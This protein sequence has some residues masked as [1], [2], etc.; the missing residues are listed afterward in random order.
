MIDTE[1]AEIL[2]LDGAKAGKVR[3]STRPI[4]SKTF[5]YADPPYFGQGK[6][7]YGK[8]HSAAADCDNLDWH[9]DLI[10]RL[11]SNYPDGWAMSL[12]SPSM[13]EILPL[14]PTDVRIAAWCKPFCAFKVGVNPAYAWEPVIFRGGRKRDR[15]QDTARDFLMCPIAMK[16]GFPG[17]KPEMFTRWILDLLGCEK[18]DTIDDL[19]PGSGSVTETIEKW[20][21]E[22]TLF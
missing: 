9:K 14:C 18:H 12:S 10:G 13:Q 20:K 16:K 19:F 15:A 21:N 7:H 8:L 3:H 1:T 4:C 22:I 6:K 5:A 2:I 17:A 11:C